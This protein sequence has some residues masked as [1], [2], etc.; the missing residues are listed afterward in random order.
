MLRADRV[1]RTI[2]PVA[3]SGPSSTSTGSCSCGSTVVA[4]IA[5]LKARRAHSDPLHCQAIARLHPDLAVRLDS[6]AQHSRPSAISHAHWRSSIRMHASLL[7][8][9]SR[10]ERCGTRRPGALRLDDSGKHKGQRHIAGGRKRLRRSAASPP[11]C[12][13]AFRWNEALISLYAR[14]R[15]KGKA[16]T[17]ALIACARKLPDLRQ[18]R[19]GARNTMGR[20]PRRRLMVA[21]A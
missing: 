3:R 21:T 20:S 16:H 8:R 4:D 18:H 17:A 9:I 10:E 19:R 13:A 11:H 1:E 2:W 5:R 15:A 12:P 7:G 6:R 14:L